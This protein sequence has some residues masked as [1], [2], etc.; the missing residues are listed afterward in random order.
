ML[1]ILW[2]SSSLSPLAAKV[3]FVVFDPN[4][5]DLKDK[6]NLYLRVPDSFSCLFFIVWLL[7]GKNSLNAYVQIYSI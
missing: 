3:Q 2:P 6:L 4:L 5:A 1:A 7:D